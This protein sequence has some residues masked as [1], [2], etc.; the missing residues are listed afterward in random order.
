MQSFDASS[1]YRSAV[2]P[3]FL[4]SLSVQDGGLVTCGSP[5][6]TQSFQYYRIFRLTFR[7]F[8]GIFRSETGN[9]FKKSR[10]DFL[11]HFPDFYGSLEAT[12]AIRGKQ[13]GPSSKNSKKTHQRLANNRNKRSSSRFPGLIY[14]LFMTSPAD[15]NHHQRKH[16]TKQQTWNDHVKN[17]HNFNWR[18][19]LCGVTK[20]IF[21]A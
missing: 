20:K 14:N 16:N 10:K 3:S 21:I 8:C 15:E 9:I 18:R 19:L 13:L 5:Q 17:A 2:L 12:T 7:S 4:A 1:P 6:V 11:G